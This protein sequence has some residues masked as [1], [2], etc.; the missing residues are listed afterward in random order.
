[1]TQAAGFSRFKSHG[2]KPHGID[3]P[4][5]LDYD[6]R[7]WIHGLFRRSLAAQG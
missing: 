1:M 6:T 7:P 5:N 3:D 2:F 4:N